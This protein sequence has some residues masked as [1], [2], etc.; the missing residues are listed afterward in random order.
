MWDAA[1]DPPRSPPPHSARSLRSGGEAE[2]LILPGGSGQPDERIALRGVPAAERDARGRVRHGVLTDPLTGLPN[3]LHFDVVYQL[4]W[5]AGGRGLPV[6]LIRFD[7]SGITSAPE[8][9]QRRVGQRLGS[10]TRQMDMIARLE[11][12]QFGLLLVACNASGALLAAERIHAELS[13]ILADLK[14]PFHAGI[15]SWRD[16]MLVAED[17]MAAAEEA[18]D[19][20]RALGPGRVELHHRA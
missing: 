16:W 18:L 8:E 5:E 1:R 17:L 20:A 9:G 6:T 3:R 7:L 11:R 10:S 12:D 19:A 2:V 14:L 4:L 15:A 13:P